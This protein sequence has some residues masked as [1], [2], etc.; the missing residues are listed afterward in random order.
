MVDE[1]ACPQEEAET[2]VTTE[3]AEVVDAE[4]VDV[5]EEAHEV[6]EWIAME[7][8]Q[9]LEYGASSWLCRGRTFEAIFEVLQSY[10]LRWVD[11]TNERGCYVDWIGSRKATYPSRQCETA[12]ETR[13]LQHVWRT[14]RKPYSTRN[15]IA[16]ATATGSL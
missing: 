4:D 12:P 6:A 7:S 2:G 3:A 10:E 8:F 13:L 14:I 15:E 5:A 16:N 11:E 1:V 9:S